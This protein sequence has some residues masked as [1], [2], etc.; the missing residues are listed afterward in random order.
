MDI[1]DIMENGMVFK[2][3]SDTPNKTE[4]KIKTKAKKASYIR[5]QHNSGSAKMKATVRKKRA[6]RNK[7]K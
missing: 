5:D 6:G 4:E 3:C 2:G 7:K 1:K